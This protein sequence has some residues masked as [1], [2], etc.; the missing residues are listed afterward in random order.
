V[1][2]SQSLIVLWSDLAKVSDWVSLETAAFLTT[3]KPKTDPIR[4]LIVVNLQG[5]NGGL[6]S[7]Q[8]IGGP[9]LLEMYAGTTPFTPALWKEISLQIINGLNPAKKPVSVPLVVLT[10]TL[11]EFDALGDEERDQIRADLNLDCE[12]IRERYYGPTRDDWKPYAGSQSIAAIIETIQSSVNADLDS[13]RL[14]WRI[15]DATFWSDIQSAKQFI[16][17]EFNTSD[18]S[19][20]IVDPVAIYKG[21]ISQR[22]MHFQASLGDCRRVI[23][24]LPPFDFPSQLIRLRDALTSQGLRP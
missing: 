19:V 7:Y 16:R 5:K 12:F 15:P 4:R 17:R 18:L 22:L 1:E 23:L 13:H 10:M 8:Q 21:G 6:Y 14:E 2:K 11:K 20:L 9:T 24:M 3:A